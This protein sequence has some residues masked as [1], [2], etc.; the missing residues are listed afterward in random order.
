[1]IKP[2]RVT[3]THL[4]NVAKHHRPPIFEEKTTIETVWAASVKH[5]DRIATNRFGRNVMNVALPTG[6]DN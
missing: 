5:A 4:Q 1:M 6:W 2:Y 3:M